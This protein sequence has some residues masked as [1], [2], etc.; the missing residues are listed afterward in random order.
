LNGLPSVRK[1]GLLIFLTGLLLIGLAAG[2]YF[3]SERESDISTSWAVT[4]GGV[5]GEQRLIS[6]TEIKKLPAYSGTGGF[7]STT[8]A[9]SGPFKVKGIALVQLCDLV[10]GLSKTSLVKVSAADGYSTMLDYEQV[11]GKFI[12]Y[13]PLT[14]KEKSHGELK[15][16]L[17]YE[18]D[19]QPLKE[20]SGKPL[21]L[22]IAGQDGYLTE[23][24]YWTKWINK[25]EVIQPKNANGGG[26]QP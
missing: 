11:Q 4:L 3:L 21:R 20:D 5:N 13:D 8:G 18:Q 15:P 19:G 2:L 25:I 26:P 10:G 7:F 6:Y 1:M 17:M 12:T 24:L 14:L 23:G 9:V 16:V 22:A